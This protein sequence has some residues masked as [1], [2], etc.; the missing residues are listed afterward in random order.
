MKIATLFPGTD[1]EKLQYSKI[2]AAIL[3]YIQ[4]HERLVIADRTN[5]MQ[6]SQSEGESAV[7]FLSRLNEA[8]EHCKWNDL[9]IADPC[10]ELIKLRFIAGL[11]D[12]GQKLKVLEKLQL[13]PNMKTDEVVAFSQMT[14][15]IVV[16]TAEKNTVESAKCETLHVQSSAGGTQPHEKP[17]DKCG[18]LHPMRNCPAFGKTCN[19]CGKL[20]HFS[21]MCRGGKN[22]GAK[23]HQTTNLVGI[24]TVSSGGN[25]VIMR[26]LQVRGVELE[27]Q[28]G[29]GATLS[30]LS[31]TQWNKLGQPALV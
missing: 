16:Y 20:K 28:V 24:F 6:I 18:R 23:R 13:T 26:T 22:N 14:E 15:Q 7:D 17:C 1:L 19:N 8:S 5:F 29:T 31:Q 21:K 30:I 2:K 10:E 12:N 11:R 25:K 27:F 4:P 9:K 3:K